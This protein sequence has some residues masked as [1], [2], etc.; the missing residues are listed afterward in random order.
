MDLDNTFSAG[1]FIT[2]VSNKS[3]NILLSCCFGVVRVA[4][5]AGLDNLKLITPVLL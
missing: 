4:S 1:G 2:V 3:V 5:Y